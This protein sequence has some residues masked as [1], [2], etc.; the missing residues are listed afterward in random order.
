MEIG[1]QI[2]KYRQ[3]GGLSQED[4]AQKIFVT[5]QTISNWENDKNYPDIK[6]LLLL[7][8]LFGVSLDIL[9]KGDLKEMKERI[10]TEDIQK[11]NQDGIIYSI[12][13]ITS[14]VSFAPMVYFLKFIGIG[15]WALLYAVT[16]YFALRLEKQKK[17]YDIHTYREI[18]AFSEGRT[19]DDL[20]KS[21]ERGKRPYQ[22]ALLVAGAA[23][24]SI[25]ILWV[26]SLLF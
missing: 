23:V 19:L 11:F 12:L 6:S 3:E 17:A 5:R 16:M 25:I 14:I 22:K 10:K 8:N 15:I 2:R 7:S 20:E 13:L 4:L 21:C 9:V 1:R 24:I 26:C 18:V